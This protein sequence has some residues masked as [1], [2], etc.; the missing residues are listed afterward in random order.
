MRAKDD[1]VNAKSLMHVSN[2]LNDSNSVLLFTFVLALLAISHIYLSY[3]ICHFQVP[4]THGHW[5]NPL[6]WITLFLITTNVVSHTLMHCY[7][8]SFVEDILRHRRAL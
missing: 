8:S 3:R 5:D 2:Y 4:D 6:K 7:S 1:M